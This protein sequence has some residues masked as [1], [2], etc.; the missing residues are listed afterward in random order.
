[1]LR[2]R[3]RSLRLV[4]EPDGLVRLVSDAGE[5]ELDAWQFLSR[6]REI[7]EALRHTRSFAVEGNSAWMGFRFMYAG[8]GGYIDPTTRVVF[9]DDRPVLVLE[10]SDGRIL[11]YPLAPAVSKIIR[12]LGRLREKG[13]RYSYTI[14]Y[15]RTIEV[16]REGSYLF[17]Y[18][19][20]HD[21]ENDKC[22]FEAKGVDHELEKS[23]MRILRRYCKLIEINAAPYSWAARRYGC[24]RRDSTGRTCYITIERK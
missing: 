3:A 15:G 7:N 22:Y 23:I 19:V 24:Q 13:K 10:L 18:R 12:L 5:E 2:V 21:Y 1:M 20:A 14:F 16:K 8:I 9:V 6:L 4:F 11:A 17:D